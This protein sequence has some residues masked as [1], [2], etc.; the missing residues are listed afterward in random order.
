MAD[1]SLASSPGNL[2]MRRWRGLLLY[3]LGWAYQDR[4]HGVDDLKLGR[5]SLEGCRDLFLSLRT[6]GRITSYEETFF[7]V[8]QARLDDL[9]TAIRNQR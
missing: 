5:K 4:A 9:E 3:N 8:I 7:P 2:Q 1:T 6:E